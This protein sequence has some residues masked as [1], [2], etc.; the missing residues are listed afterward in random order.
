MGL[1]DARMGQVPVAAVVGDSAPSLAEIRAHLRR[2]LPAP[3]IPV[4]ILHLAC[5]PRTARGKLDQ[6]ALAALFATP[7]DML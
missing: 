5:L 7:E 2:V 4:R 1:P 6:R 3:S